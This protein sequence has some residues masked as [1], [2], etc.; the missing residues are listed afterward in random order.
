MRFFMIV[1]D[2]MQLKRLAQAFRFR[3]PAIEPP[4]RRLSCRPIPA[5]LWSSLPQL[6][7]TANLFEAAPHLGRNDTFWS[8]PL[9]EDVSILFEP[10]PLV[11][12]IQ[13]KWAETRADL[14]NIAQESSAPLQVW[15][16]DRPPKLVGGWWIAGCLGTATP[17]AEDQD[18][19]GYGAKIWV[20]NFHP[21]TW[22][23]L[24]PWQGAE[25]YKRAMAMYAHSAPLICLARDH[26]EGRVWQGGDGHARVR[27][28]GVCSGYI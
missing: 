14:S 10:R 13:Q 26:G 5:R 3:H 4:H 16:R 28:C 6:G 18:G 12:R 21:I 1:P 7:L 25:Q 23:A 2:R 19:K 9:A 20:P 11:V 22:G 15:H 17:D 24:V 27:A 8:R